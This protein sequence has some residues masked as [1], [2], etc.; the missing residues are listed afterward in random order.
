M[1]N[2]FDRENLETDVLIMASDGLWDI[3]PNER[4]VEIVDEVL[5]SFPPGDY[6]K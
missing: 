1:Y 4:V 6:K 2:L 3:L 5:K